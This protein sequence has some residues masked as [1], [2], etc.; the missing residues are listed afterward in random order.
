VKLRKEVKKRSKMA[1]AHGLK[2]H[3]ILK[4]ELKRWE[5]II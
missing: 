5:L 2:T 1:F 4:S 3:G